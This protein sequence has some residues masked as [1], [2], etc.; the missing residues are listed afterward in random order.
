M[1]TTYKAFTLSTLI[2][3]AAITFSS[4]KKDEVTPVTVT[5]EVNYD[6]V[7]YKS[8]FVNTQG[9]TTVDFTIGN[10]RL[11]MY[12]A[13]DAYGKTGNST[14]LDAAT[15]KNMFAN[16][17]SPFTGTY[18][19]LN[20]STE[21]L[22][23]KTAV[24]TANPEAVRTTL[25]DFFDKLAAAS[26]HYTDSAYQGQAG[27]LS[28]RLLDENGIEWIQVISK[29]LMGAYQLDYVGNT[30]LSESKLTTAN[31]SA[32]VA[33]QPYT[34]LEHIWDEAYASM[35]LNPVFY[36][37]VTGTSSGESFLGSYVW[38][39][40]KEDFPHLNSYFIKGRLAIVNKN[41]TE[42]KA[43]ALNIRKA[44]EKAIAKAAIGYMVKAKDANAGTAA[45]ALGEGL[46]FVYSLRFCTIKGGSAAFSDE[47]L[48]TL[49][50]NTTGYWGITP[51]KLDE[52]IGKI[53]TK[54]GF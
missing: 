45:H 32:L 13:L 54:F 41:L 6:T 35:T 20:S 39:Y 46:G 29:S 33:G 30:L 22:R 16:T 17:G 49:G 11:N 18:A 19:Y 53:N 3:L 12:K 40:N 27:K 44:F 52:V 10:A 28:N 43:Q 48:D 31:N 9:D 25:E 14:T 36:G 5:P 8:L 38:E 51:S 37:K 4:C 21:Q 47:L 2:G 50:F 34:E 42:V 26:E 15:L 1:T 24:S 23:N 7:P